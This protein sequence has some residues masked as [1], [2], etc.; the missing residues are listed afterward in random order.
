VRNRARKGVRKN[1]AE[2]E[3]KGDKEGRKRRKKRREKCEREG[4]GN[5]GEKAPG[6]AKT[7]KME[8]KVIGQRGKREEGR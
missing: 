4:G 8:E 3:A 2:G 5:K 7:R 6:E 1:E